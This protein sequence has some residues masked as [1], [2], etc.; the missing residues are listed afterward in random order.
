LQELSR[1]DAAQPGPLQVVAL[2]EITRNAL[3][4]ARLRGPELTITAELAPWYVRAEPAAL[5]RAVVNV[6]DNAVKFS[7]ARGTVDVVLHRGE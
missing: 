6:L 2:H 4:R 7:P 1:P 5:E 3:R